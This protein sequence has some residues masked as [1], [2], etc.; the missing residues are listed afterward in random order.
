MNIHEHY[1][2]LTPEEKKFV[3]RTF[4]SDWIGLGETVLGYKFHKDDR[5]ERAVDAVAKWVIESR[6]VDA[7]GLGLQY[8]AEGR[9]TLKTTRQSLRASEDGE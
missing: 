2:R 9:R 5:I 6:P 1:D 8:S 7:G 4:S 3:D